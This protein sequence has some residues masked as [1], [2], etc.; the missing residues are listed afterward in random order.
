MVC[1]MSKRKTLRSKPGLTGQ[2]WHSV[3]RDPSSYDARTCQGKLIFLTWNGAAAIARHHFHRPDL[4]ATI[5]RCPS[6]RH[7]HLRN[8]INRQSH[9]SRRHILEAIT[10]AEH[11]KDVTDA[12]ESH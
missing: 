5:Y 4:R 7:F 12:L 1:G 10:R 8:P 2:R 3:G 6:C 9:Q 11:D